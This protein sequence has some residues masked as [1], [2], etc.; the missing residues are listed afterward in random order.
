MRL[1]ILFLILY[2]QSVFADD[3]KVGFFSLTPHIQMKNG[4]A[5]GPLVKMIRGLFPDQNVTFTELAI[6]RL[7]KELEYGEIDIAASLGKNQERMKISLFPE[8]P[9]FNMR[10][11]LVTKKANKLKIN[12]IEDILSLSILSHN[13]GFRS[14]FIRDARL[15]ITGLSGE[16]L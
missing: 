13:K 6:A 11:V 9:F 12:S 2:S 7:L 4:K 1:F 3:I 14:Q 5:E 15:K 16:N 8:Q 10:P